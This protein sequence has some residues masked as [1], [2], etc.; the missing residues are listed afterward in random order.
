[1]KPLGAKIFDG[2]SGDSVVGLSPARQARRHTM[3]PTTA[4]TSTSTANTIESVP[5]MK[6]LR[7]T[8]STSCG[9]LAVRQSVP[10][11][12]ACWHRLCCFQ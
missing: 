4:T 8:T 5:W 6:V 3:V 2:S 11:S 1:M 10:A 9:V 7:T 12:C